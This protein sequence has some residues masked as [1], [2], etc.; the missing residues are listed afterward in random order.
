MLYERRRRT[1]AAVVLL[2]A[3][4]L[5]ACAAVVVLTSSPFTDLHVYRA[6]G[7][8]LRSGLDLY[9]PLPGVHGLTTYPPFAAVVFVP[10]TMVPPGVLEALALLANLVLVG[11]V[12]WQSVRRVHGGRPGAFAAAC[13]LA[14]VAVWSEPVTATID[15]G[16]VNLALLAL[17]LWD[18]NLPDD[19]RLRGV[20]VGLASGLKVTPG[21]L[22]V[23]LVLTGRI[24]AAAT[25]TGTL[26][27]TIGLSALASA[28]A[29]W[30]YWTGYLFDLDRAGRLENSLNQSVRGWLVRSDHS[31][32]TGAL[33][34]L[35]VALVLVAGL[36]CAVLAHRRLGDAWGL[37]A[38][39][40]TG[41]LVSPITWSHHWVWCIPIVAL[42]WYQAWPFVV[43]AVLVF[44]SYAV[45][46]VPHGDQVELRLT[47]LQVA[48]SAWYVVFGLAFLTVTAA[49]SLQ[50]GPHLLQGVGGQRAEPTYVVRSGRLGP[51][52]Q[53]G[54]HGAGDDLGPDGG[55]ERLAAALGEERP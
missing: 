1:P 10:A 48:A 44:G 11:V 50:R 46:A 45:W 24:R 53:R 39:A 41:L 51:D 29:A 32:E 36:A 17:V 52:G 5:L 30:S 22:I 47:A 33:A 13:V 9:G 31:R 15:Y 37:P 18:F 20:G 21:L 42:L 26:L 35:L 38:A 6:E 3:L 4:S 19:S 28:D 43:P 49:L 54:E 12:S 34:L 23:Y 16:Q 27:L 14:S 8:A 40:V 25:A 7:A 55:R 2:A